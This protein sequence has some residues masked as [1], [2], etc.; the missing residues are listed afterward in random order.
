MEIDKAASFVWDP[1][2]TMTIIPLG[3]ISLQKT[4][5]KIGGNLW[6]LLTKRT[7]CIFSLPSKFDSFFKAAQVLSPSFLFCHVEGVTSEQPLLRLL[8]G[9]LQLRLCLHWPF[10]TFIPWKSLGAT[11]RPLEKLICIPRAL[12]WAAF[13]HP[14]GHFPPSCQGFLDSASYRL[15]YREEVGSRATKWRGGGRCCC[16]LSQR[17]EN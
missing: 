13:S 4:R 8:E 5:G 7:Q 15:P 9:W 12:L 16:L 11:L 14:T 17:S 2:E 3:S 6:F 1:Q 10:V